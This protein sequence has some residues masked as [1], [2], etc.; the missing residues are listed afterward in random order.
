VFFNWLHLDLVWVHDEYRRKGIGRQLMTNTVRQADA[1][2]LSGIEVWT[3]SWQAP[4]FYLATGFEPFAAMDD[5]FPGAKRYAF[6]RYLT[7][8]EPAS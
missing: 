1:A 8:A 7:Q 5:F 6:R 4:E 2:G 3:Q